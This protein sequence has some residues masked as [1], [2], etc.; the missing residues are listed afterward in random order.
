V[1]N[2][3]RAL[4]AIAAAAVLAALLAA[5]GS[6][7][8]SSS[9][10]S[11]TTPGTTATVA[12]TL[13]LGGPA[14]CP[15]RQNCVLGLADV[16][17]VTFK[18]FKALDTGG[19]ITVTAIEDGTVDVG[20]LF[21]TNGVISANGWVLLKDDKKLQPADNVTPVLSTKITDAYGDDL[22][23]V[24]NAVSAKI[25]TEAMTDWN[26]QTDI[27][28]KDSDAVAK[29]WLEDNDL[30]PA[31]AE[32]AKVGPTIVIGSADFSESTT[33]ANVYAAALEANGYPVEKKL[34]IGSREVYWPAMTK[35][36]INFLPEYAGTLITFIDKTATATTDTAKNATTL[37]GLLTPLKLTALEP[38]E[39]QDIN[40]FV[41]TKETA[42]KYSLVNLS[43]LAQPAS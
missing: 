27:D 22:A 23:A 5:C 33:L 20:V 28:K 9:D 15:K 12:S 11:T 8:S 17:G 19:P 42:D 32:I 38:S 18:S 6:S 16:Y 37:E 30:L 31:P 24:V 40:G 7:G 39:A 29:A 36:E 35:G 14:E 25:T 1:R 34:G 43:D 13:T 2:S 10:T 21:T 4:R 26:K 41:V 3:T